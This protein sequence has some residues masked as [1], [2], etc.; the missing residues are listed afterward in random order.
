M[1]KVS[2]GWAKGMVLKAPEGEAT[3]PTSAK[4]REAVMNILAPYLDDSVF[5]DIFCGSGALGIEA[6]S[7]GAKSCLFVDSSRKAVATLKSNIAELETR[8]TR[9]KQAMPMVTVQCGDALDISRFL[10]ET[11]PD[12][13]WAD[14]PYA[15]ARNFL[16]VLADQL[17]ERVA[18]DALLVLECDIDEVDIAQLFV[19]KK[20]SLIRSRRYGI[21]YIHVAQ[22]DGGS[23]SN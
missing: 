9:Q 14:P 19:G 2:G 7:R 6:L 13:V 16:P 1:M 3:R 12:I 10:G 8:A 18:K 21:T 20:W 4:V 23:V 11:R 22:A 17:T 15:I 5:V